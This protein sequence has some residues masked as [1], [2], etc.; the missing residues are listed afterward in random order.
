MLSLLRRRLRLRT[1]TSAWPAAPAPES[2]AQP[3]FDAQRCDLNGACASACPVAAITVGASFQLDRARCISCSRCIEVCPTHALAQGLIFVA[4]ARTRAELMEPP[5]APPAGDDLASRARKVLGRSLQVRHLDAG[6]C[7]GCDWEINATTNAVHDLQRFGIDFVASPRHADILL[8]TGTVT[9]N[10][11]I[12]ARRTY[13]AMSEPKLVV[14][15][16]ACASS[17]SPYP[18]GYA[19]GAGAAVILPIDVFI[20]GCPPR[21]EAIIQGLL[22]AVGRLVRTDVLSK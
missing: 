11:E 5:A 13:D 3:I 19:S 12:A 22:L 1:A 4:P 6:S 15:V 16:G 8:V 9:R 21:P 14:A 10:L 2:R 7:N 20:P 18:A 17:G